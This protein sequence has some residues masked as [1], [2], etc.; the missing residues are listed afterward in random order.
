MIIKLSIFWKYEVLVM[1]KGKLFNIR[2]ITIGFLV[3]YFIDNDFIGVGLGGIGYN[4]RSY[5]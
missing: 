4:C 3:N 5:K 2:L 1:Y